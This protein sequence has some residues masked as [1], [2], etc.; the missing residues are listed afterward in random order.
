VTKDQASGWLKK[1]V[2]N[3]VTWALV[4]LGGV[5]IGGVTRAEVST[6]SEKVADLRTDA[7]RAETER[8][9]LTSDVRVIGVRLDSLG[10]AVSKAVGAVDRLEHT[11]TRLEALASGMSGG[12]R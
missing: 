6:N 11:V 8:S 5:W 9:G 10:E 7:R 1:N 12:P 3:V 4:L 2:A